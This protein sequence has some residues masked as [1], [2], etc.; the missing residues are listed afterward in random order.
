MERSA[1]A[2]ERL[3]GKLRMIAPL[4]NSTAAH[5]RAGA[6]PHEKWS[7]AHRRE[8]ECSDPEEPDEFIT[9]KLRRYPINAIVVAAGTYFEGLLGALLDGWSQV[10][11]P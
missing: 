8:R 4:E 5:L 3:S 11:L 6:R 2:H 1:A 7:V 9:R 10:Y